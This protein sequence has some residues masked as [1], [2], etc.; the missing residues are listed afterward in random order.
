MPFEAPQNVEMW[1][2]TNSSSTYSLIMG[3]GGGGGPK[4]FNEDQIGTEL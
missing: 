4:S 1:R 2:I 3:G